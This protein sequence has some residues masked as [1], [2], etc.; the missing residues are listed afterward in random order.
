DG[1][2]DLQRLCAEQWQ[3]RVEVQS[4]DAN[5]ADAVLAQVVAGLLGQH[6]YQHQLCR[7]LNE[8]YPAGEEQL[9]AGHVEVAFQLLALALAELDRAGEEGF[10]AG[11]SV[12]EA[13]QAVEVGD[14]GK[15]RRVAGDE[16]L[17]RLFAFGV[18]DAFEVAQQHRLQLRMQVRLRFLDDEA[19]VAG[20]WVLSQLAEHHGHEDQIVEA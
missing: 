1:H 20:F 3:E 2:R 17:Y 11:P 19:A 16:Q 14:A 18:L 7:S 9:C 6:I 8:D 5:Q 15:V 10:Y 4:L 13:G 12:D